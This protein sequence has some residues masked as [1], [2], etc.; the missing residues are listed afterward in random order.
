M[1]FSNGMMKDTIDKFYSQH[2]GHL[3]KVASDL[4]RY[5]SK[6]Y[7]PE[8]LVHNAYM[9]LI[10]K[11]DRIQAP[12]QVE[13]WSLQFI[14]MQVQWW[15]SETNRLE[16]LISGE[17]EL[18]VNE[19]D[20]MQQINMKNMEEINHKR[21][22]IEIYK[23]GIATKVQERILEAYLD[24]GIKT[25]RGLAEHFNI[26]PS[27]AHHRLKEIKSQLNTINKKC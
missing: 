11:K 4:V 19:L 22:V 8:I 14:K 3:M 16:R 24:K 5:Y 2:Y 17:L 15:N 25:V 12:E 27:S 6:K 9:Y 20:F 10:N 7:E 21:K 1:N 26:P 18:N 23:K 13:I